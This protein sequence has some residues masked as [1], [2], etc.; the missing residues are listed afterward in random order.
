MEAT[1]VMPRQ[2]TASEAGFLSEY[3]SP[4]VVW[5][6]ISEAMKVEN[7]EIQANDEEMYLFILPS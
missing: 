3:V 7:K 5:N 1:E 4:I 6:K 2:A